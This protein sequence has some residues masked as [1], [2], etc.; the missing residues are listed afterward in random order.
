MDKH[1]KCLFVF[2]RISLFMEN[3]CFPRVS[4]LLHSSKKTVLSSSIYC[5]NCH[6]LFDDFY[7]WTSSIFP[8]AVHCLDISPDFPGFLRFFNSLFTC[9]SPIL[10]S[11]K[12]SPVLVLW[13]QHAQGEKKS[14]GTF[15]DQFHRCK[16]ACLGHVRCQPAPGWWGFASGG[17]PKPIFYPVSS[18]CPVSWDLE[19]SGL[20]FPSFYDVACSNWQYC[21]ICK[22]WKLTTVWSQ[23]TWNPYS[24]LRGHGVSHL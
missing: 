16:G 3:H 11:T 4:I 9:C 6:H 15:S 22:C 13:F 20:L 5:P 19:I 10:Y 14:S 8:S 18:G 1:G 21:D 7:P 12:I 2:I 17:K 24:N 23:D